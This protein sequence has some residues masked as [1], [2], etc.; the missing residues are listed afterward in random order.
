[1]L[2]AHA[3]MLDLAARERAL[4]TAQRAPP[5]KAPQGYPAAYDNELLTMS[6]D[7]GERLLR[8]FDTKTGLPY[9]RVNLRH[10]I[11]RAVRQNEVT[12]TACAGTLI[13]EFAA[14]SRFSNDTR[15]EVGAVWKCG[16]AQG[17]ARLLL[18]CRASWHAPF[19]APP[20]PSPESMS[21]SALLLLSSRWPHVAR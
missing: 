7:L 3:L 21:R 2:S 18:S 1:L 10:G 9:S 8:A 13:L 6:H 4:P 12:C 5:A 17:T 20:L 19:P 16:A 15:F 11:D 14:L